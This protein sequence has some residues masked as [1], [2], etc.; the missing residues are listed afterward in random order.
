MSK[1]S[2]AQVKETQK[3][4]WC[5]FS[6]T[7]TCLSLDGE[8]IWCNGRGGNYQYCTIP[9]KV[10]AGFH[11][12]QASSWKNDAS[13]VGTDGSFMTYAKCKDDSPW[14]AKLCQGAEKTNKKC[15]LQIPGCGLQEE[16]RPVMSWPPVCGD[17]VKSKYVS[18]DQAPPYGTLGNK[19]A[20]PWK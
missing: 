10:E 4:T 17:A 11:F 5:T 1:L 18:V 13:N 20:R 14:T 9:L 12:I 16:I 19:L 8:Q 2:S 7:Y 15:A 6:Q 3:M